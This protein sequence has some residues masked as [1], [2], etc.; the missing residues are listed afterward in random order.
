MYIY[1]SKESFINKGKPN[2]L[3]IN[4]FINDIVGKFKKILEEEK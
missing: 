2:S 1:S 3:S 4:D